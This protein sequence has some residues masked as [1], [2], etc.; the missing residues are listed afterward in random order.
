MYFWEYNAERAL[1]FAAYK[2]TLK[3][4]S[5]PITDP[6]VIGAI[7][8][9]GNCLD[10]LDSHSIKSLNKGYDMLC[11]TMKQEGFPLPKNTPLKNGKDLIF[12]NLDC[13]VIE[14]VHSI[15]KDTPPPYDSVRGVFWEGDEVYKGAGFREQN[16]IQICV[17]NPNCIK[18][19]FTPREIHKDQNPV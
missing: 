17:R 18:A 4:I 15:K 3:N 2:A 13:A 8:N 10:L 7:I 9:L 19:F 5:D 16:H 1:E 12:R 11:R 14:A 6:V